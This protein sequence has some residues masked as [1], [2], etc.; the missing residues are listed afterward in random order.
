MSIKFHATGAREHMGFFAEVVTL[1]ISVVGI[2]RDIRH[3]MSFSVFENNQRGAVH[4]T[5][6]GEINPIVTM[7]RNQITANCL[8]LYGNFTTCQSSVQFDIQN[9]QDVF[10][11]N[12]FISR[13]IGGLFIKA[14]SSGTATA[15]RGLLH[16]NIF[17]ENLKKVTLYLEGRQT[18]PYQQITM[19]R[20]YITRSN[21]SHEPV[22]KFN[23]VVCNT[24]YN[25][26]H[27]NRGKIIMEVTGFDNVRLPIYQ[28]FTHNGFYN[29]FAYGLHC[30]KTTFG[31]CRWGSRATVVAGS[32]GQEYVD[33][34]FYN[35]YFYK[36]NSI[37][38]PRHGRTGGHY[39][40]AWCP[41]VRK[42]KKAL[43]P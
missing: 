21:V 11:Y 2:D 7:Q 17:E 13:N 3:N 42:S 20:N 27:N 6:A 40:H 8:S 14:G 10:F 5:S 16:N 37:E 15:M 29:N 33:N 1:P 26:F 12:N 18:S 23:Q 31:Y 22:I 25:T 38:P 28:S 36:N 39:F 24:T 30:E 34:V 19:Y 41:S 32:A 9:T 35:R 43:K 4:Y